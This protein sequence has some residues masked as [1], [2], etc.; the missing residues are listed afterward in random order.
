VQT[1]TDIPKSNITPTDIPD[2]TTD[3]IV[4]LFSLP[5]EK[6]EVLANPIGTFEAVLSTKSNTQ[7]PQ[8]SQAHPPPQT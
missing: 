2:T 3:P 7:Q 5:H 6:N 1:S 8:K 4:F